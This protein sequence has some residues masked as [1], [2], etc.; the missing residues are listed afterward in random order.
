M[1]SRDVVLLSAVEA[2]S[3]G[4]KKDPWLSDDI[5]RAGGSKLGVPA[6]LIGLEKLNCGRGSPEASEATDGE[7]WYAG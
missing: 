6:R 4:G 2:A 5:V 1:F 3:S 7:R